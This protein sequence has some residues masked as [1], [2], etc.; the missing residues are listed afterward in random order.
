MAIV[1]YRVDDRLVHGQ[2]V[3]GWGKQLA[4]DFI[5]LVDDAVAG[6]EWEQDL[7][8]MGVP[9]DIE[10][11]FCSAADFAARSEA[12]RSDTR[13]GILITPDIDTMVKI[14]RTAPPVK[15]VNLGGIHHKPGR[16]ERLPY[17]YLTDGEFDALEG[18]EREG[19]EVMA[20]DV[21][22]TLPVPLAELR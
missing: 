9:P 22:G 16:N 18:L 12:W 19:T 20:Q 1:L 14:C 5:V 7:Y 17:V 8:R 11:H 4:A 15:Q 6:S 10:L 13:T 21:P 3:I 2:V